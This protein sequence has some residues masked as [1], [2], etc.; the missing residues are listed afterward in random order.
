MSRFISPPPAVCSRH[1][2]YWDHYCELC[3][4]DEEDE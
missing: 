2:S 1:G 4:D 3:P